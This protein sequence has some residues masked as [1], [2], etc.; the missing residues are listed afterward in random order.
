MLQTDY[1]VAKCR[2]DTAENELSEFFVAILMVM[3]K[4]SANIGEQWGR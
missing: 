1:L 3:K 2:F 4:V